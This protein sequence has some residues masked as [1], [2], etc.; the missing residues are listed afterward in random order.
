MIAAFENGVL[1]LLRS[2]SD[3]DLLGYRFASLETY[4]EDWDAWLKEKPSVFKGPAAWIG[5]RGWDRPR[6]ESG[7][8]RVP[9]GFWLV[10]MAESARSEEA[11]RHGDP[12]SPSANPGSY[13]LLADAI[14][15]VSKKTLGLEI[16]PIKVGACRPVR[17]PE[18]MKD[19]PVSM[20]AVELLTD[21]VLPDP[22]DLDGDVA[23]FIRA[24]ID[25]DIPAFGGIDAA[26]GTP[27]IQIP[28]PDNA[29]AS[30]DIT[31]EQ[32]P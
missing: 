24:H 2:A 25:W 1:A 31:L 32:A 11:R 28:D 21:I 19:K 5:F 17:K 8:V 30:D 23:D 26:P 16:S 6:D 18:A 4:P 20:Y 12:A 13:R 3:N 10:L 27:G 29:D 22:L 14:A 9:C 7:Q 15:L